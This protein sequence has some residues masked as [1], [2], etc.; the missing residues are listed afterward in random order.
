[1]NIMTMLKINVTKD[2]IK[3]GVPKNYATCPVAVAM[4]RATN[5]YISVVDNGFMDDGPKPG[6]RG[7]G[8]NPMELPERVRNFVQAFDDVSIHDADYEFLPFDF[9][10]EDWRDAG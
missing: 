4:E 2:D 1:M 10:V 6:R 3:R 8:H 7:F 5:H 9:E